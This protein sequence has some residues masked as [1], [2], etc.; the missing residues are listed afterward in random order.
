MT[1]EFLEQPIRTQEKIRGN[2]KDNRRIRRKNR[3]A[4]T[5]K[6]SK[7]ADFGNV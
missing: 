6:K 7:T 3:A 1:Q 2:G 5:G 4:G